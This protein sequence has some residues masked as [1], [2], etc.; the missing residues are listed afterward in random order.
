M[1]TSGGTHKADHEFGYCWD[2]SRRS[3][4]MV[5]WWVKRWV[6][7]CGTSA[8][9]H[10]QPPSFYLKL[11]CLYCL[12]NL[13]MD[14]ESRTLR[15][16]HCQYFSFLRLKL[17]SSTFVRVRRYACA[18]M[19]VYVCCLHRVAIITNFNSYR[20]APNIY[21]WEA[22]RVIICKTKCEKVKIY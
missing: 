13:Q 11:S 3:L 10:H 1:C 4:G 5:G 6:T 22:C 21:I 20:V 7:A 15:L 2:S 8:A 16:F 17:Q 9:A 19:D 18:M 12:H 14:S